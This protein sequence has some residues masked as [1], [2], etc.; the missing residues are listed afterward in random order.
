V[1]EAG[2]KLRVGFHRRF[3]PSFRKVRDTVAAGKIGTPQVARL[4]S[5]EPEV[6]PTSYIK[7]SGGMFLDTTIHDLDMARFL[8]GDEIEEIYASGRT[9]DDA[10]A[11]A[12]DI[13]TTLVTM[14][15]R[16][17]ALGIIDGSRHSGFRGYDQRIEVSGSR[18]WVRAENNNLDTTEL[19]TD[20]GSITS[21]PSYSFL[22]RYAEAY[23]IEMTEFITAIAEDEAPPVTGWDG[24]VAVVMAYAAKKSYEENLPVRLTEVD[25]G[26]H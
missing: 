16:N 25:P 2:V 14:R 21:L 6:P 24:R 7:A 1:E 20:E 5:R 8:L 19:T 23:V 11:E 18:G 15:Y 10:V 22:E 26:W 9:V 4:F 17:G 3:D 13:D 12:G